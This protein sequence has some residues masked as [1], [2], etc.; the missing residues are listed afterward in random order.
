MLDVYTGLSFGSLGHTRVK[1]LPPTGTEPQRGLAPLV[2]GY[3]ASSRWS[4]PQTLTHLSLSFMTGVAQAGLRKE[5]VRIGNAPFFSR[6]KINTSISA[7]L[8]AKCEI[9]KLSITVPSH[10][11]DRGG[12]GGQATASGHVKRTFPPSEYVCSWCSR[13]VES[14]LHCPGIWCDGAG[15]SPPLPLAHVRLHHTQL[16]HFPNPQGVGACGPWLVSS[17]PTGP[18]LPASPAGV[19][20]QQ[21]PL[22]ERLR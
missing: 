4:W 2:Q 5:Y 18:A 1:A 17:Q 21:P 22:P 12:P 11:C 15:P 16:F 14:S 6:T 9:H 7:K 8:P 13:S 19:G 10:R 20:T 3:V